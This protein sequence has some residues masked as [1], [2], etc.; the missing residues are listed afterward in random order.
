[1]SAKLKCYFTQG[2]QVH[3]ARDFGAQP[4]N[5]IPRMPIMITIVMKEEPHM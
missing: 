4:I 2:K 1:M 5:L 3:R